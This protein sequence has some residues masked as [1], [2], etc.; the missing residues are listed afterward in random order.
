MREKHG[1]IDDV[2]TGMRIEDQR[3][4]IEADDGDA[5]IYVAG[6]ENTP[7]SVE[8]PHA[9]LTIT[10]D[11]MR[12]DITLNG[13]QLDELADAIYHVQESYND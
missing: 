13:K 9:E 7:L 4:K 8:E 6:R 2:W 10:G 3:M 11:E 12:T 1:Q 5:T